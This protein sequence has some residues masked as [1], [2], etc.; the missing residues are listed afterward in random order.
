MQATQGRHRCPNK[1]RVMTYRLCA[2]ALG[3]AALALPATAVAA[4]TRGERSGSVR[5]AVLASGSGY[6]SRGGSALVRAL[7]RDLTRAGYPPGG[8]D[9]LFGPLTRQAVVEFQAAHGLQVDGVAGPHTWTALSAPVLVVTPGAGDRPGGSTVVGSLQRLLAAAGEPPGPID[10]RYGPL[11]ERAVRRFQTAHGLRANGMAG[12]RTF[13]LLAHPHARAPRTG[14]VRHV[15]HAGAPRQSTSASP[16]APIESTPAARVPRARRHGTTPVPWTIILSGLTLALALILAA[17]LL[18]TRRRGDRR[19]AGATALAT[20]ATPVAVTRTTV[21]TD[22][23][24]AGAYE[25][26]QLLE[27]QGSVPEAQAAYRR[28]DEAGHPGAALNLGR[29]LE[30][31]GALAAAEAA[32]RRADQRGDAGGAF[33]LGVLLE[34]RDRLD[35]AEAAY[36]RAVDRGHDAAASN[37]GVLLEERGAVDEAERAYRRADDR[38]DAV[39]AFNL[40]VLL[41]ERGALGEA[42]AAYRR[43]EQRGTDDVANMARAALLDLGEEPPQGGAD[44]AA[45]V[46]HA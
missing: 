22:H 27:A 37:L 26:A 33:N 7:Q 24:A 39:A 38:G 23:E 9:G 14:P 12:P 46:R 28:A 17:P 43:A 5:A 41:E 25:L 34:D 1:E 44:R 35:A 20:A 15:R 8:I 18:Y 29:L 10:G 13:A 31:Q 3:V 6:G 21:A 42:G 11:T 36:R 16:P 4:N 2:L 30:E 40:G 32:Y 45:L 19:S